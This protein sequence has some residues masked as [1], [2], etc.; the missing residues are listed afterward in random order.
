M[1]WRLTIYINVIIF[2]AKSDILSVLCLLRSPRTVRRSFAGAQDD[3]FSTAFC[4]VAARKRILERKH[5]KP[6][7][8]AMV[9]PPPEEEDL[10]GG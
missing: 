10:G 5:G 2:V 8:E 9:S 1:A 3:S 4:N 7:S 6:L